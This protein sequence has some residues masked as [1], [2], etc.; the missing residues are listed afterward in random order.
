LRRSGFR[1]FL[2]LVDCRFHPERHL[3][4]AADFEQVDIVDRPFGPPIYLAQPQA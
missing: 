3:R 4:A 1:F 2:D